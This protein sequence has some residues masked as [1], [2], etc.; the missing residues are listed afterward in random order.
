MLHIV[1]SCLNIC[2]AVCSDDE[3]FEPSLPVT[4]GDT[5]KWE[6][7]DEDE[8]LKDNWDDDEEEEKKAKKS[9]LLFTLNPSPVFL[10][11]C[12]ICII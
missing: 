9:K 6:G 2:F 3:D 12:E 4:R 11:R 1:L 8:P 5:D 10:L 7:E